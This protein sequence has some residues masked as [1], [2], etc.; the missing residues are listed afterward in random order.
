[1]YNSNVLVNFLKKTLL[2]LSM[3]CWK[4]KEYTPIQYYNGCKKRKKNKKR[5][6]CTYTCFPVNEKREQCIEREVS[7][8]CMFLTKGFRSGIN[9][10]VFLSFIFFFFLC[11]SSYHSYLFSLL[12]FVFFLYMRQHQ[13]TTWVSSACVSGDILSSHCILTQLRTLGSA[14]NDTQ[15]TIRMAYTWWTF[16]LARDQSS[17]RHN[18]RSI[19]VLH[20]III[21][22]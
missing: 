1:M 12:F 15:G 8:L 9:D 19:Y 3:I 4:N 6:H 21:F 14:W 10:L 18:G 16:K 22:F 20:C 7:V 5:I 13:P 11:R 17:L 2:K